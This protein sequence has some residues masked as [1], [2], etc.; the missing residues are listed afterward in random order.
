[1][2]MVRIGE[3]IMSSSGSPASLET[4]LPNEVSVHLS[5]R[6]EPSCPASLLGFVMGELIMDARLLSTS[7]LSRL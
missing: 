1:M 7:L 6:G 4:A 3:L 2:L 5:P